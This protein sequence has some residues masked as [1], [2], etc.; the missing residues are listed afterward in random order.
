LIRN[1]LLNQ[2]V[3][4]HIFSFRARKAVDKWTEEHCPLIH[5]LYDGG[6]DGSSS[7]KSGLGGL[8]HTAGGS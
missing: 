8:I 6:D 7:F 1:L 3:E 4:T 5:S 2:C